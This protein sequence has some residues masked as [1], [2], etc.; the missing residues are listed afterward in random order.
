MKFFG[1]AT[2]AMIL[3]GVIGCGTSDS[4]AKKDAKMAPAQPEI[5]GSKDGGR[6][7][8]PANDHPSDPDP[9]RPGA[10]REK[11]K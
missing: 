10:V 9:N 7:G 3:L 4:P 5:G 11:G 2:S 8:E 6:V 1:R